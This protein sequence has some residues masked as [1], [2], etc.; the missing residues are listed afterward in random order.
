MSTASAVTTNA[1]LE[2]GQPQTGQEIV[3]LCAPQRKCREPVAEIDDAADV[4][5]RALLTRMRSD[6]LVQAVDVA[7]GEWRE[8]NPH[9]VSL[10]LARGAA[11]LD[12]P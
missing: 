8:D 6:V 1:M 11:C 2:S 12:A 10:L 7:L 9:K 4:A 3:A 5:V